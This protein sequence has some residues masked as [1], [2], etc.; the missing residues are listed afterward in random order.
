M[1]NIIV[2]WVSED[3]ELLEPYEW[4]DHDDLEIITSMEVYRVNEETLHDFIYGCINLKDKQFHNQIFAVSDG[5]YCV[6]VEINCIGKLIY[7][8]L[9]SYKDRSYINI[10]VLNKEVTNFNFHK[11]DE[12]YIKEYGLTRNERLKKQYLEN[13]IDELYIDDYEQFLEICNQ[14]QISGEK[15]INMYLN[16]KKKMEKGYNFIHELLY[17]EL[18]KNK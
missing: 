6:I 7:R 3:E 2:N 10:S 1:N 16:L 18:S 13:K 15:S 5:S 14:L 12:G 17:N 9:A 11:Y 8:S 4:I